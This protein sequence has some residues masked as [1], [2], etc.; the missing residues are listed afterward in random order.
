MLSTSKV[1]NE[2]RRRSVTKLSCFSP[3]FVVDEIKKYDE[4]RVKVFYLEVAQGQVDGV[5][6][7]IA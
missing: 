3:N 6:E 1:S 5:D 2:S 4:P 7:S